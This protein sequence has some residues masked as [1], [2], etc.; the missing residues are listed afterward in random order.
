MTEQ[1]REEF[2][3]WWKSVGQFID[4]GKKKAFRVWQASRAAVVIELPP[5]DVVNFGE[6]YSKPTLTKAI[7][8]AGITVK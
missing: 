7:K 5:P 3:K 6:F 1:S 8:A 4:I 2:E